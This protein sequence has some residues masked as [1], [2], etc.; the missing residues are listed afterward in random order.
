MCDIGKSIQFHKYDLEIWY[1][2]MAKIIKDIFSSKAKI[3]VAQGSYLN[4]HHMAV[5][6][7]ERIVYVQQ[8]W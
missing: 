4:I 3:H 5:R 2:K 8:I 7:T 6:G 1:F